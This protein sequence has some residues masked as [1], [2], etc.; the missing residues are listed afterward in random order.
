MIDV[1]PPNPGDAGKLG[2]WIL[3]TGVTIVLGVFA[4]L[5]AAFKGKDAK[6]VGGLEAQLVAKDNIIKERDATIVRLG[7]KC[8]KLRGDAEV[9]L[10]KQREEYK[11]L[12]ELRA[13]DQRRM[14]GALLAARDPDRAT[15][16]YEE[17][18]TGV[19]ELID[20]VAPRRQPQ[21]PPRI[22]R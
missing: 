18:P 4:A 7:E 20:I 16:G 15:D 6:L 8:D 22:P 9:A 5:W 2:P 10:E 17:S 13:E 19:R 21:R 1:Q 11:K 12:T 14:V 3:S